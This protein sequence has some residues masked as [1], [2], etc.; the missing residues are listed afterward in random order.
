QMCLCVSVS[1]HGW[2]GAQALVADAG[3]IGNSTSLGMCGH[4]EHDPFPLDLGRA[5][6]KAVAPDL[7]Y[8]PL[9]TPFLKKAE[10]AGL[11]TLDGLGML[12][13]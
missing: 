3:L 7:V 6:R 8:V 10:E 12:Q 5:L 13:H 11:K 4:D 1:A 9:K 2:D